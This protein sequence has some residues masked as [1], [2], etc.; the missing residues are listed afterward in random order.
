MQVR[1][2]GTRDSKEG[3]GTI[4][5]YYRVTTMGKKKSITWR[6]VK[7]HKECCQDPTI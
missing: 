7:E 6:Y 3:K 5:E 2:W 4:R 1:D